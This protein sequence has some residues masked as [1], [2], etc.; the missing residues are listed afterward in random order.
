MDDSHASHTCSSSIRVFYIDGS[1]D[2]SRPYVEMSSKNTVPGSSQGFRSR[3]RRFS[4]KAKN[5]LKEPSDLGSVSS[6]QL[7]VAPAPSV[8]SPTPVRIAESS[9]AHNINISTS[10]LSPISAQ[11]PSAEVSSLAICA[12]ATPAGVN[13]SVEHVGRTVKPAKQDPENEE[14][15]GQSWIKLEA[16]LRALHQ[17][18]KIFPPLQS[19]TNTLISCLDLVEVSVKLWVVAR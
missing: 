1:G 4:N 2:C 16:A 12:P 9:L 5:M 19:A 11:P 17:T 8:N 14:K 13:T 15:R 3:I 18:S 7:L 10:T 6:Q